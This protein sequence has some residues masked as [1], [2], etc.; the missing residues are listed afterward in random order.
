MRRIVIG[1][2]TAVLCLSAL[3]AAAQTIELKMSHF[4]APTH[5]WTKDFLGA[6]ASEVGTRTGG[7]VKIE[8]YG[9]GSTF[10]NAARQ[11][12]QVVNGVVD[13]ANGLRSIPAGRF[14][15]TS[16]IEMPFLV[17]SADAATRTLWAMYPKFLADEYKE[18]KVLVLHAHN[19]ALIHTR[20]K[21][22]AKMEDLKGMRIRSPGAVTNEF[23][24]SLG[25]EPVGMPPTEIYE[26][27]QKGVIEGVATTWDL[28][29]TAKLAEVTKYHL[30][31]G[32]YVA[33]FYFV[34]NKQ[35]YEGLPADV[36]KAIDDVSGD[37]LVE[38]LGGWWDRWDELG[39]QAA[40]ARGNVVNRLA[41]E[42]RARWEK[43]GQAA[44]EAWL[45]RME[46]EGAPNA[47]E[48]YTEAKRL[49]AQFE[50]RRF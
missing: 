44:I 32:A 31:V 33:S 38:R 12:D 16:I 1:S 28:L 34:M 25:A 21:Q 6:W 40:A 26:N 4:V 18:V 35:R 37:W 3:P 29:N 8:I 5:E 20:S 43:D 11:Y 45:Q 2:M 48:L 9:A 14:T 30:D 39:R 49:V 23:L 46:K 42:E 22:I 50:K 19:G 47:R 15:K 24:K 17:N 7:R 13:I 36:R 27:L 10:G 41:P